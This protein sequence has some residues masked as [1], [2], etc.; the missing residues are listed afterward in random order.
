MTDRIVHAKAIPFAINKAL[1]PRRIPG[2][3]DDLCSKCKKQIR[4]EPE[5]ITHGTTQYRANRVASFGPAGNQKVHLL[6]IGGS[7]CVDC[8]VEMLFPQI[9]KGL[10]ETL[11]KK[12]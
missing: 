8:L 1:K 10:A 6:T 11:A 12:K 7:I 5:V 9:S 3:N 4:V 2:G